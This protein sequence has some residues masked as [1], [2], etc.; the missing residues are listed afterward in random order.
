MRAALV[1]EYRK[2][3]TT[4]LWWVL[5]LVMVGYMMFIAG[6]MAWAFT[7]GGGMGGPT[8]GGGGEQPDLTPEAVVRTVY[9]IAV[10]FG[11]VFPVVVG[12]LSVTTEF[13]HQT[14]TPTLLAEPRR[15]VVL[16]AK[17]VAG[18]VIGVVFG[19]V[20]TLVT[21][22]TG[23]GVLAALGEPTFLGEAETWRTLAL[24]ALALAMWSVVGVALGTVL[25]NQ[26]AAIVV[27]IAFTQ[28]VEPVLRVVLALTSWGKDIASYLPGAAG[29]AVS[30]GSFYAE[31][32]M[33]SLLDWW[34]G[35]LVLVAYAVVLVVVGR[36]TTFRRDIT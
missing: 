6:F 34:Q 27:L 10:T 31:A 1:T 11:Y 7:Q 15:G 23:A 28:F 3:V 5:L 26:V 19:T 2:I 36:A 29:E 30:G 20:A 21:A 24:S 9:T 17:L 4:R 8:P 14:I 25:T 22:G 18:L 12:A 33:A 16:V 13:R 32:G 35:L